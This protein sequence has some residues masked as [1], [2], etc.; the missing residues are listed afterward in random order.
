MDDSKKIGSR[1]AKL[2]GWYGDKLGANLS[3]K[4]IASEV[5]LNDRHYQTLE[6]GSAKSFTLST[7]YKINK[8]YGCN[9]NWLLTGEGDPYDVPLELLPKD[10]PKQQVILAESTNQVSLIQTQQTMIRTMEKQLTWMTQ[11][12]ERLENEIS[13]LRKEKGMIED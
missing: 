4:K 8:F 3:Q 10:T 13:F 2:R 5:G 6:S 9:L 1:L 12:I 11:H 7:L